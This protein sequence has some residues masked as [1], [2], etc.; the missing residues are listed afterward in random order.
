MKKIITIAAL[1][2]THN[3]FSQSESDE[4]LLKLSF[5][6]DQLTH[7]YEEDNDCTGISFVNGFKVIIPYSFDDFNA[8]IIEIASSN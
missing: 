2:L 3:A 8:F 6:F 1:F 4:Q 7:Y 5:F